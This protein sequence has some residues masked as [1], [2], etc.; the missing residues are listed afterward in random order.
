MK[1]IRVSVS[2]TNPNDLPPPNFNNSDD[3]QEAR[4]MRKKRQIA[5]LTRARASRHQ[6]ECQDSTNDLNVEFSSESDC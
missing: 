5:I 6:H 2:A 3:E 1:N 4:G